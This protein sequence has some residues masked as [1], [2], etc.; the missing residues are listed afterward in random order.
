MIKLKQGCDEMDILIYVIIA[1]CV[2]IIA[3]LAVL[4]ARKPKKDDS[5]TLLDQKIDIN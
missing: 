2:I 4:I 1:L 3:L 5:V